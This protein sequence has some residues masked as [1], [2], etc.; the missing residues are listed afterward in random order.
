MRPRK[1]VESLEYN[2]RNM[3]AARHQIGICQWWAQL[4]RHLIEMDFPELEN[5][6]FVRRKPWFVANA[7]RRSKKK[8]MEAA[9]S[10]LGNQLWG[11]A[12]GYSA[13]V[14]RMLDLL[15]TCPIE[16][17][18]FV[19]AV[20]A[21]GMSTEQALALVKSEGAKLDRF[22]RNRFPNAIWLMFPEIDVVLAEHIELG[23]LPDRKWR[24]GVNGKTLVYKVHFHGIIY[25]HGITPADVESSFKYYRSGK[26]VKCFSGANQIRSIPLYDD[27]GTEEIKPDVYGVAGYSTKM[28]FRPPVPHRPLEGFAEWCWV[29]SMVSSDDSLIRIGGV[30]AGIRA[31]RA[32]SG[33]SGRANEVCCTGSLTESHN[34]S[35]ATNVDRTP[36]DTKFIHEEDSINAGIDRLIALNCKDASDWSSTQ[37]TVQVE[38][39][40]NGSRPEHRI[41]QPRRNHCR[42]RD[43]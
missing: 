16:H 23:L 19:T 25:A 5:L 22:I 11:S 41:R 32:N 7:E 37:N 21:I 36:H 2:I 3:S 33:L 27:P 4:T 12:S 39:T 8:R 38:R 1:R 18:S 35:S 14:D 42:I 6:P 31:M 26:R 28:H 24:I 20:C 40:P 30:R 29:N 13:R 17:T 9:S 43:S 15:H 34:S 10:D